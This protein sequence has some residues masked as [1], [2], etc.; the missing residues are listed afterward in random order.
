MQKHLALQSHVTQ[1]AAKYYLEISL[2]MRDS[3]IHPAPTPI[4][5]AHSAPFCQTTWK[6]ERIGVSMMMSCTNNTLT[7]V[8]CE[9]CR[10]AHTDL[11]ICARI[12]AHAGGNFNATVPY[13]K[14]ITLCTLSNRCWNTITLHKSHHIPNI[15]TL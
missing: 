5:N 6:K 8:L 9:R 15:A 10:Y 3:T 4:A 14:T 13:Q 2:T 7:A 1:D 12:Y 11:G